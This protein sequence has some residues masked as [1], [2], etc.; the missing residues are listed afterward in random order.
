MEQE[1]ENGSDQ[2]QFEEQQQ[3]EELGGLDSLPPP[4]PDEDYNPEEPKIILTFSPTLLSAATSSPNTFQNPSNNTTTTTFT[5][6]SNT[7]GTSSDQA[8]I[9]E[10]EKL[11]SDERKKNKDLEE[12]INE[13]ELAL[14]ET[15]NTLKAITS[16]AAEAPPPPPPPPGSF[17]GTESDSSTD[18]DSGPPPPPPPPGIMGGPPP[19][20]GGPSGPLKIVKGKGK[21]APSGGGRADLLAGIAAFNKGALKKPEE[22]AEDESKPAAVAGGGG[23]GMNIA[24]LAAGQ[25]KNLKKLDGKRTASGRMTREQAQNNQAAANMFLTMK[26]GTP[27]PSGLAIGGGAN[28]ASKPVDMRAGLR[29]RPTTATA[30]NNSSAATG[31]GGGEVPANVSDF[32]SAL[33]ASRAQAASGNSPPSTT[34]TNSPPTMT[35]RSTGLKT[36]TSPSQPTA[37]GA[38]PAEGGA[39]NFK[40]GLKTASGMD[41]TKSG[42]VVAKTATGPPAKRN[43]F[44]DTLR[45]NAT[46]VGTTNPPPEGGSQ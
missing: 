32:K 16:A 45:R 30:G 41:K 8:K 11:L 7:T 13:L 9:K 40:A 35:L 2:Q 43:D 20:S 26:R 34:A 37:A 31:A 39:F 10:L 28:E 12:R 33:R 18:D 46:T 6:N 29:S 14:L 42:R 21:P 5:T 24:A 23:G 1:N 27:N 15:E 17:P 3:Q 25:L 36:S 22:K 44:R 38:A 4:P 19:P